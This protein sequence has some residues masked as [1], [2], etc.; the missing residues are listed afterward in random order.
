EDD[1]G[2]RH[3]G[4]VLHGGLTVGDGAEDDGQRAEDDVQD[5]KADDAAAKARDRKAVGARSGG[6]SRGTA[7]TRH[8]GLPVVGDPART[9]RALTA[10]HVNPECPDTA[11]PCP[12]LA[13][14]KAPCRDSGIRRPHTKVL[15][16]SDGTCPPGPVPNAHMGAAGRGT[17][18]PFTSEGSRSWQLSPSSP[19][20]RTCPSVPCSHPASAGTPTAVRSAPSAQGRGPAA[21]RP[22]P[23]AGSSA[24]P[25]TPA[26]VR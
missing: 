18:S 1:A 13:G 25:S 2:L 4:A 15:T 12:W 8:V 10:C 3:P 14:Q 26:H 5:E 21:R 23:W 7:V 11:M 24:S 17:C 22:A 9:G 19:Y 20:G 6:R 16:V